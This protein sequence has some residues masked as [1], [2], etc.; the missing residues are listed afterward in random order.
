MGSSD[1]TCEDVVPVSRA[2]YWRL[3]TFVLLGLSVPRLIAQQ[4]GTLELKGGVV[5]SRNSSPVAEAT[6]E[7][8][9]CVQIAD[10][11]RE[12]ALTDPDGKF[13][14]PAVPEGMCELSVEH[15]G[16]L[17][18]RGHVDT[19]SELTIRLA[20]QASI[21]GAVADENG[22]PLRGLRVGT[23]CRK[24]VDGCGDFTVTASAVTDDDGR[25]LLS[26]LRA[27]RH[28]VCIDRQAA[29]EPKGELY[30]G[31]SCIPA[32]PRGRAAPWIDL[33]AG[34]STEISLQV[35]PQHVLKVSGKIANPDGGFF[36]RLDAV[37]PKTLLSDPPLGVPRNRKAGEFEF[38]ALHAGT[39][40]LVVSSA[41]QTRHTRQLVEVVS[42]DIT[43]LKLTLL[44]V[45]IASGRLLTD[46]GVPWIRRETSLSATAAEFDSTE[47][48]VLAE[49]GAFQIAM[50]FPAI[51]LSVSSL[52]WCVHPAIVNGRDILTEEV[53]LGAEPPL[54]EIVLSHVCGSVDGRIRTTRDIELD[55]TQIVLLRRNG[56]LLE[57]AGV[58]GTSG[59]RGPSF[60]FDRVQPG[61][62]L[63]FAWPIT[64]EVDY[65]NS[66]I[67]KD[68][69][70]FGREIEVREGV[71]SKVEL[72][73]VRLH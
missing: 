57:R 31:L 24:G 10:G 51:R 69:E 66:D 1:A 16:F 44:P 19:S 40:S 43:D 17:A 71:A 50:V 7:L 49:D 33:G 38:Q 36:A 53:P 2:L 25:F 6:V 64:A 18:H 3:S 72:E 56:S 58:T 29:D 9:Y 39:Y 34:E 28:V 47:P 12:T 8:K 73:I 68:Y 62:Y 30:Y 63:L 65:L 26:N 46:N 52:G 59:Y 11:W 14:F 32:T 5:D 54:I 60:T 55:P 23:V 45:P 27:G 48:V 61:R 15:R 20:P 37:E 22:K 70:M 4:P 42:E 67:L 13:Y 41:D 21:S 35:I